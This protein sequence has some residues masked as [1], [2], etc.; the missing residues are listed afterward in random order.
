MSAASITVEGT[1]FAG[2]QADGSA[3]PSPTPTETVVTIGA[4]TTV[5]TTKPADA[6]ALVVGQCVSAIGKAD[7][8]GGYAATSL[9]V[10]A[11]GM[12]GCVTT[13]GGTRGGF[14]GGGGAQRQRAVR[15]RPDGLR[16]R[17]MAKAKKRTRLRRALVWSGAAVVVVAAAAIGVGSATA[18][19][20]ANHYRTATATMG[21]VDATLELSGRVVSATREDLAFSSAGTVDGVKVKLGDTVSAGDVLATIDDTDLEAAVESAKSDLSDAKQQ[22]STDLAAIEAASS[23]SSHASGGGG[24]SLAQLSQALTQAE[25]AFVAAVTGGDATTIADAQHALDEAVSALT[26]AAQQ[27]STSGT[28]LSAS[29]GGGSTPTAAD[30]TADRAAIDA[31]QAQVDVAS[32]AHGAYR[33]VSPIEGTVARVALAVG[34]E[35]K[36]GDS[37]EAITVLGDDGYVIKTTVSL[38]KVALLAPGQTVKVTLA[39]SG[40]T[41]EGKVASVGVTDVSSTS[42]P[43]YDVVLSVDAKG[44]TILNGAAA[45]AVVSVGTATNVLTV[46]LSALHTTD[47]TTTVDLLK[48]G[49]SVSAKVA[50]GA[51]GADDAEIRDGLSVGDVVVI[52]DL[53][54]PVSSSST[55]TTRG[56]GATLG[57]TGLGGAGFGGAGLTGTV[58]GQFPRG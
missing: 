32:A 7:D 39:A 20:A 44:D 35:V 14:G 43:A 9:T 50:V 4:S 46:P 18:A 29:H 8:K 25:Q 26:H 1:S 15:L 48:D 56:G 33:L 21:E 10:F 31:A 6:S 23:A 19:S 36:A 52:A 40:K 53:D 24:S 3:A 34:D 57:V 17:L 41:Y 16:E 5:T 45:K 30:L 49:K 12:S 54:Q 55:T 58:T 37:A 11:P 22:L 42:T 28:A 2:G 51:I 47:G 13:V 27:S 38:A